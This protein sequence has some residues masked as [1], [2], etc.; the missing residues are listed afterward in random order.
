MQAEMKCSTCGGDKFKFLGGN[1]FRCVYCGAT[2]INEKQSPE[3]EKEIVYVQAPQPQFQQAP[4][5]NYEQIDGVKSKG[6]A[7]ALAFFLGGLGMHKFYLGKVGQG[8]LYL[9]FCW[10]FVPSFL[11]LIDFIMLI[12]MGDAEFNQKY[13]CGES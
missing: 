11:A 12:C 10:T 9:L 8:I 5:Q 13:N 4:Q 6:L 2:I 1:S 7:A 3:V